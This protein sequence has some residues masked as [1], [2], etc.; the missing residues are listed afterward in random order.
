MIQNAKRVIERNPMFQTMK[1]IH[2]D[3]INDIDL[4]YYTE[5]KRIAKQKEMILLKEP[6]K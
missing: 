5:E 2:E 6:K 1:K 4:L 3:I